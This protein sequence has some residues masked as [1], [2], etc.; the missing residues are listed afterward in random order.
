MGRFSGLALHWGDVAGETVAGETV[1]RPVGKQQ[2]LRH[3]QNNELTPDMSGEKKADPN[4]KRDGSARCLLQSG[5][6]AAN[7][8]KAFCKL[9]QAVFFLFND[10]TRRTCDKA[11]VGQFALCL[12]NLT[13]Q[14]LGFF[15]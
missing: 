4:R 12:G 1:A 3:G 9:G 6:L 2:R 15:G 5:L 10:M 14:A 7:A 11:F 13:F 8:F